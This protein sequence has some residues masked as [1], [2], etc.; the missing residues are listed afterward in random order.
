[1]ATLAENAFW[2]DGIFQLETADAV[3]AGEPNAA[4]RVGGPNIAAQQL[5]D[6][7]LWLRAAILAA[8]PAGAILPFAAAS[9]PTGWLVCDGAEVLRADYAELFAEIGTVW[10]NGDDATTFALPDFRG[11]F[12]RGWD[13]GRGADAGRQFGSY[14]SHAVEQHQHNW[15]DAV[16]LATDDDPPN[17]PSRYLQGDGST[18]QQR[19]VGHSLNLRG[20]IADV[21]NA[22]TAAETRPRNRAVLF[23]IKY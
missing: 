3:V 2:H 1:M 9:P 8:V 14:Q 21:R 13:A 7:T 17:N 18:G 5:A 23:C 16:S 4:A 19:Y 22:A 12:L 6:R 11:E 15:N 20:Y 10:G